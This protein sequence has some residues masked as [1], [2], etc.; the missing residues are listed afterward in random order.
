MNPV[1]VKKK[2]LIFSTAYYPFVGG[3]EVAVKE[4]TD[5][6][7]ES[8]EFDLITARF[9]KGLSSVEKIGSVTVYR[10]GVGVPILDKLMLPFLGALK[11]AS[12]HSKQRYMYFWAI[13]VSFASGAPFI[14][15]GIRSV[16]GSPR[17]PIVLTLQEGDSEE[18]LTHRRVGLVGLAW[19]MALTRADKVTAISNYLLGHAKV[20]GF[21]G[22]GFLV[23]NGVTIEA[24]SESV[25]LEEKKKIR[26][27]WRLSEKDIILVTTSRLTKKNN[28]ESVIR[29]LA[30]LP[31]H[32]HFII[33]GVGEEEHSLHE[34]TSK[35]DVDKRVHFLGFVSHDQIPSILKSSDIFIRPSL[36]EGMGNSFIEA[37]A[38]NI[39]V[40]AT[41]VGG[42]VDFLF[43][44]AKNPDKK[45]TGLFCEVENPESI[46][47]QV[48]KYLENP[49]LR[50]QIILEANSMVCEKY[51]WNLIVKDLK[52]K[53]F[54]TI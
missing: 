6:M 34:L 41:P 5:R 17:V 45:S 28:L 26:S 47:R 7:G 42:I 49:A 38:A 36:S 9:K 48:K 18:H 52:E 4:I 12:L 54:N 31:A 53:V 13:M 33:M 16:F 11:I 22:Q 29:A 15:N 1:M 8:F 43:D 10:I 35:L 3:A 30:L 51:D 2:I 25:P 39:P 37:M 19:R 44:P 40:I 23:P 24:F 14:W 50:E 32:I 27:R 21:H 46:A 20:W